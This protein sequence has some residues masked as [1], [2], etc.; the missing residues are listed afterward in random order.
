MYYRFMSKITR[1]PQRQIQNFVYI[2]YRS[3][4]AIVG[5]LPEAHGEEIIAIGRYYL[6]PHTNRAEAAFTVRDQW[7][8]RGIATFLMKYLVTIAKS[9]GIAGFTAEVLPANLSML[10]VFNH[11]GT[12][13]QSRLVEGVYHF[14]MEF[15]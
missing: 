1:I 13:V 10:A 2:D 12:K 3:E 11:S 4:M 9:Y 8:N 6:D 14:E 15:V 7:Q 5:T